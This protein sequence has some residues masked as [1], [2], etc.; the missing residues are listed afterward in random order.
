MFQD[1]HPLVLRQSRELLAMTRGI[2]G[3]VCC[4]LTCASTSHVSIHVPA[5]HPPFVIIVVFVCPASLGLCSTRLPFG[6]VLRFD[7]I[8]RF[9]D[10]SIYVRT[11]SST[12]YIRSIVLTIDQRAGWLHNSPA[13]C[14]EKLPRQGF[15]HGVHAPQDR[16]VVRTGGGQ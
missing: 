12:R 5:H 14:R 16:E 2:L 6:G 15:P 4:V 11:D 9:D 13:P 10:Y 3:F 7:L 1:V 8:P